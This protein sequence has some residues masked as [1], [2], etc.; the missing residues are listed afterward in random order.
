MNTKL[1]SG[2]LLLLS[3]LLPNGTGFRENSAI[4]T[5]EYYRNIR[6]EG[7]TDEIF[8][9]ATARIKRTFEFFPTVAKILEVCRE[10]EAEECRKKQALLDAELIKK[11]E[12]E[13]KEREAREREEKDK[14]LIEEFKEMG[15]DYNP[16]G[17]F[18]HI[19]DSYHLRWEKQRAQ[20]AAEEKAR[21]EEEAKRR[22]EA[23]EVLRKAEESLKKGQGVR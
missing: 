23:A 10:V 19:R 17:S 14:E 12:Q 7:I 16:K 6:D 22:R 11:F 5:A 4:L 15:I 13:S 1:V 18:E 8:C 3:Q 21:R 9:L 2:E 20:K